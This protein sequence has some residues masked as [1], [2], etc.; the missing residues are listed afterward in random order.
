MY[1][2]G[3]T[4]GATPSPI[5]KTYGV[6]PID[7]LMDIPVQVYSATCSN[8]HAYLMPTIGATLLDYLPLQGCYLK[9]IPADT[10]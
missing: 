9:V 8:P 6:A 2:I 3:I 7:T 10:P 1:L 4:N 5:E